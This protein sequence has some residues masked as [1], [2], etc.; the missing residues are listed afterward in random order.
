ME[1]VTNIPNAQ[2]WLNNSVVVVK[3]DY[4]AGDEAYV[5]NTLVRI[6]AGNAVQLT[7]KHHS[8]VLVKRMVQHGSVVAVPRSGGRV[9][10]VH[11]P[12][13][14]ENLLLH[15]LEYIVEQ[16]TK[17]NEPAMTPE[18]QEAFPQPVSEH[19]QANLKRVK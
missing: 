19:S 6:D 15:D 3:E 1:G 7:G 16:I 14:A 17:L 4:T 2:H 5:M 13:E 18:E 8:I 10:T 9:K 12:D 11:L